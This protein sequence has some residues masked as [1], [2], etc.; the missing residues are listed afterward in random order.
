MEYPSQGYARCM[1]GVGLTIPRLRRAPE[2]IMSIVCIRLLQNQHAFYKGSNSIFAAYTMIHATILILPWPAQFHPWR[3]L[4]HPSVVD[5]F[6]IQHCGP[7]LPLSK[8]RSRI[9]PEVFAIHEDPP[10]V[11][12]ASSP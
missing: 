7:G 3:C 12:V 11:G 10:R 6:S 8:V 4:I 1:H 5:Y 2:S 9:A